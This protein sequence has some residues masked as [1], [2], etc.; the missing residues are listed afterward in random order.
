MSTI[1]DV[2]DYLSD[3]LIPTALTGLDYREVPD[4]IELGN[5]SDLWFDKG[6]AVFVGPDDAAQG[7]LKSQTDIGTLMEVTLVRS[8]VSD[9]SDAAALRAEKKLLK[10]HGELVWKQVHNTDPCLGDNVHDSTYIGS[11]PIEYLGGDDYRFY[12]L[13][14]AFNVRYIE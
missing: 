10:D 3:T 6:F 9:L 11:G 7:T 12:V 13:T 8:I 4:S 14:L 5:N 2:I 1:S